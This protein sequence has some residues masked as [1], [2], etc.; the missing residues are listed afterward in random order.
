MPFCSLIVLVGL[1]DVD[2][3]TTTDRQT[4]RQCL[5][6]S[7]INTILSGTYRLIGEPNS[8]GLTELRLRSAIFWL[9]FV[10]LILS[11][12]NP[13]YGYGVP[14]VIPQRIPF[15]SVTLPSPGVRVQ[16]FWALKQLRFRYL[17]ILCAEI[18]VFKVTV[19]SHEGTIVGSEATVGGKKPQY[20]VATDVPD[21]PVGEHVRTQC[22]LVES[23]QTGD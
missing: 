5:L 16:V 11:S 6:K 7:L 14:E 1:Q 8:L 10:D 12:Y 23:V 15:R 13:G 22:H 21:R 17:L 4:D 9:F 20:L 3:P 18:Y 19:P 2:R